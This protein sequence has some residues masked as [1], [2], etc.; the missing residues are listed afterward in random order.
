MNNNPVSDCATGAAEVALRSAEE[1]H[2]ELIR[3]F[4]PL[5]S[6][7]MVVLLSLASWAAICAVVASLLPK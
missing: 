3:R 5:A 1:S 6:L 7:I 4:S 2:L